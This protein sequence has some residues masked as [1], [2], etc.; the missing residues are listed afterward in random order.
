MREEVRRGK[1]ESKGEVREEV[2]GEV[3]EDLRKE[4]LNPKFRGKLFSI[5]IDIRQTFTPVP[6]VPKC[7]NQ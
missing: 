5:K 1:G 6:Q 2:R 3:R 4:A 7:L